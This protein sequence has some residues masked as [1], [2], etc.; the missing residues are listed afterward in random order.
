MCTAVSL[1]TKGQEII[2]GRTMDF[3]HELD[4][5]IYVIPKDYE[6]TN[7]FDSYKF[8]NQYKIIGVGQKLKKEILGE[9]M[10]EEGLGVMA[11]YFKGEAIYN[12]E[13]NSL[14]RIAVGSIEMVNFLLGNCQNVN[15][16]IRILNQI[17]IVG[18]EDSITQTIAPL[19]WLVIDKSGRCI[20]IEPLKEGLYIYEN[21]LMVLTN[22]P[23][24][25]WHM[26]NLRNYMNLSVTQLEEVKLEKITLKPF[27]EGGGMI[28]MPGD[29]T[30]P[31]RFV[32]MVFQKNKIELPLDNEK[33]INTCFNLMKTVTIPKGI[34]ITSR[35]TSDYT[36]YTTF[37]NIETGDY[38]FNTY[39][40]N[41]IL[42][43]NLSTS[44]PSTIVSL[45]QLKQSSS[46]SHI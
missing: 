24:F 8:K 44:N 20:T 35:G 29:F 17:D 36:Q 14:E 40:N 7:A 9:G 15:D 6:W 31:S 11:L 1:K 5:E 42:K 18:V 10:N 2:V 45:G 23:K 13:V 4:P 3:S 33:L 37:M 12:T 46:I 28:G 25:E 39:Y 43:V 16:V 38:Y 30:S 41:Q 26:T 34:V 27:G 22:S 32:R 19:H 21:P